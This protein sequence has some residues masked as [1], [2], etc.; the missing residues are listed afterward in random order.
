MRQAAV[1]LSSR[2]SFSSLVTVW[3]TWVQ[4]GQEHGT[5]RGTWHSTIPAP[6]CCSSLF[7][8]KSPPCCRITLALQ[9]CLTWHSS[10]QQASAEVTWWYIAKKLM[11]ALVA[12]YFPWANQCTVNC[13]LNFWLRHSCCHKPAESGTPKIQ[14]QVCAAEH[15]TAHLL[16]LDHSEGLSI[17]FHTF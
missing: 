10:L 17:T 12:H 11:E 16:C 5:G 1:V 2:P 14:P 9:N 8:T 15:Y 3:Q 6:A 13:T 4:C 7:R